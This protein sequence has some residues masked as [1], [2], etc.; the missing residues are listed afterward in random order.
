MIDAGLSKS[1]WILVLK[2]AVYV[3]NR[4]PHKGIDSEIPIKKMVPDGN[5]HLDKIRRFACLAYAKMPIA[6]DKFSD[7]AIRIIM[8]GYSQNRFVL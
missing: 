6:V 3:Y 7:R 2:V 8:V 5:I 4:T 1:M